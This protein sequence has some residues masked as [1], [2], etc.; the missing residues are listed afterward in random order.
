MH[1][2]TRYVDG[3]EFHFGTRRAMNLHGTIP[4]TVLAVS[5]HGMFSLIVVDVDKSE[6]EYAVPS[7]YLH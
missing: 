7:R 5:G 6:T 1:I 2:V 4:V 3:I